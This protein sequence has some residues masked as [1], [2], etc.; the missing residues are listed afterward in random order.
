MSFFFYCIIIIITKVKVIKPMNITVIKTKLRT[1]YLTY[2]VYLNLTFSLVMVAF[3]YTLHKGDLKYIVEVL[4]VA[5]ALIQV[6]A[7][8]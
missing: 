6:L 8:M 2:K 1:F 5:Q 4:K 7:G 3:L